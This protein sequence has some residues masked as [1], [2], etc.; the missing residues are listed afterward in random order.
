MIET[1]VMVIVFC[2]IFLLIPVLNALAFYVGGAIIACAL[3][4]VIMALG[5]LTASRSSHG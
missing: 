4:I 5:Y 1:I 3:C 2:A